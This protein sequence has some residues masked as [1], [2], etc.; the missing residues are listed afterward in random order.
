MFKGRDKVSPEGVRGKR[1]PAEGIAG[2]PVSLQPKDQ[3]KAFGGTRSWA[4]AQDNGIMQGRVVVL[5]TLIFINFEKWSDTQFL[6]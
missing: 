2:R 4:D 6:F 3:E 5:K 1:L